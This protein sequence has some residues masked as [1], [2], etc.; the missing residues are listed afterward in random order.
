MQVH[1]I[2]PGDR[3]GAARFNR[4]PFRLYRSHP[5]WVPP[6][7]GDIR[8]A[9]DRR[10]HPFYRRGDAGFFLA[11]DGDRTL[12]RIAVI[13]N[14]AANEYRGRRDAFFYYFDAD[15]D[16]AV[17]AALL[18]TAADWAKERGLTRLV[19]PK[20]MLP[21]EGFG[22]LIEGF[23]HLPA[24]A[25]PYNYPYYGS[26]V[27][28]A[29]FTKETDFISG[30]LSIDEHEIPQQF[31]ELADAVAES[32][33]YEIKTF[34]NR[35]ELRKWI[36]RI[37]AVY[38]RTFADNWEFW[39]LSDEEAHSVL[40]QVAT[41]ADPR[42][43]IMLLCHGELVGHMFIIPNIS[44]ALQKIGGRLWP[45]GWATL[46][47]ARAGATSVDF[48]GI[49]LVPEH[50]GTGAN[51]VIYAEIARGAPDTQFTSAELV[52]VDEANAPILTNMAAIGVDWHKR[53]RIYQR[54]L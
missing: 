25:V 50:R 48:L 33:G 21:M 6:L 30:R 49:G 8:R 32:G 29:G 14:R 22:V 52:Q 38:N 24:L 34:R 46:L 36:P 39:P 31:L 53:H 41:V 20:G 3:R 54:D 42:R 2:E 37:A 26:L 12:G 9:M 44:G 1:R 40:R 4:V 13:E 45:F 5:Q 19:G 15:D 16:P 28:G 27:E 18:D 11:V 43:I 17:A 10:R 23:E 35:R 7:Q 51:A 47:R